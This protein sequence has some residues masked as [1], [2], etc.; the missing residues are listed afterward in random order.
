MTGDYNEAVEGCEACQS[1]IDMAIA[2]LHH[3]APVHGSE[4]ILPRN[5]RCM[6]C[7][8][9]VYIDWDSVLVRWLELEMQSALMA[10]LT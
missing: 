1:A 8:A 9:L 2:Y 10:L 7:G 4:L 3:L 6:N 5:L